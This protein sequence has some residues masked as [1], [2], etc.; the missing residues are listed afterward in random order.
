[1]EGLAGALQEEGVLLRECGARWAGALA[2][3]LTEAGIPCR[4]G[5]TPAFEQGRA[6]GQ[7][8]T[9]L[10]LGVFVREQDLTAARRV[11]VEHL[12][13]EV[14]ELR[15]AQAVG[16]GDALEAGEG[17]PACGAAVA[18]DA[19]ECPECGLGFVA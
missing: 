8:V 12:R 17:C 15:D 11:D 9:S 14:P 5:P 10:P 18:S 16:S 4:V 3:A 1:M 6:Q 7:P 13:A 2:D 19:P